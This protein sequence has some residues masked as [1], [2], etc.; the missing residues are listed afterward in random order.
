LAWL[1]GRYQDS[2]A[3]ARLSVATRRPRENIFAEVCKSAGEVPSADITAKM[4]REGVDRRAKTPFAAMNFLKAMRG[5]FKWAAGAELVAADPAVSVK[6]I[7]PRTEGYHAWTDEEV[8]RFETKWPIGT[9]ER[10]ALAILLYTGLR[11]GDAA[12][13]GRQHTRE[14]II[15]LRTGKTG[16]QVTIPVLP[17]LARIIEATPSTGN[18]S[19]IGMPRNA[20]T[21]QGRGRMT[22]RKERKRN[23][24]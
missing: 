4:I 2:A 23:G 6:F 3:W 1:I 8:S 12:M 9:K 11:R 16:Q 5:V 19:F 24:R 14:G 18:L 20:G 7:V 15:A 13:L 21:A 17:E 10:L 22:N